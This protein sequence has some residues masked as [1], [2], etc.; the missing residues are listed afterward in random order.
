MLLVYKHHSDV[1]QTYTNVCSR[2][3]EE[4]T[5]RKA[6]FMT[7]GTDAF[8]RAIPMKLGGKV[9]VDLACRV[10]EG[11]LKLEMS[12]AVSSFVENRGPLLT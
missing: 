12:D 4:L 10:A 2:A 8:L 5:T 1:L 7:S 11:Y 6:W 9:R 3:V